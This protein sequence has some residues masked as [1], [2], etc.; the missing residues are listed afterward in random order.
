MAT[1]SN[2]TPKLRLGSLNS[3]ALQYFKTVVLNNSNKTHQCE[4][5]NCG[6][7]IAANKLHSLVSHVKSCHPEI[8]KTIRNADGEKDSLYYAKKR[9][10]FIQ[11]CVELVTINCRP[12]TCLL[13]SGFKKIIQGQLSE[14]ENG[15]YSVNLHD[16]NL[17][18][19]KSYIT[20]LTR[21]ISDQIR[22]E[23]NKR[24]L[25]VMVDIASKHNKSLLGVSI[26][27]VLNNMIVVRSIG[28][29]E[30]HKSHTAKYILEK[31]LSC[32]ND[33]GINSQQIVSITSDNA[34]NMILMS[35]LFNESCEP[36]EGKF[37]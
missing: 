19:I 26:Q 22:M 35:K 16:K 25:S 1:V 5:E 11:N 15:S 8:F 21:K 17:P 34:A 20:K 2:S 6:R 32:L 37:L 7:F 9:L 36:C 33:H 12:F 29:V 10:Q 4:I 24:L 18:E 31:M 14:L 3:Q 30:L 13:D 27:Y 28:M 23:V